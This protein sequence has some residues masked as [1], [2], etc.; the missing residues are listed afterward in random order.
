M[1]SFMLRLEAHFFPETHFIISSN[2]HFKNFAPLTRVEA[3]NK[4]YTVFFDSYES[5]TNVAMSVS[6]QL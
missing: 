1:L 4:I 5:G 2:G 6:A 3:S